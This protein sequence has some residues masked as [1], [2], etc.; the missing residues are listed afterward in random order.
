MQEM[1]CVAYLVAMQFLVFFLSRRNVEDFVNDYY[2][3][4][5]YLRAY[6]SSIP[7]V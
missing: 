2:K 5:A 4:E 1:G 6:S 7:L 3:R